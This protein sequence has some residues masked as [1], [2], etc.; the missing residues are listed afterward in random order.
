M[1]VEVTHLPSGLTVVTDAMSHLETA[2]LGV[3]A[4]AGARSEGEKEHGLAHLL[5]HMAFK[6]TR[7][8]DAKRIAEEIESA[9]GELNAATSGEQ[10]AYYAR[11][12]KE[13]VGLGFDILADIL[14]QSVFDSDELAREKNVILQEISAVEDTPDD[15]VFD[16]FNQAAFPHQPL[17]RP[18]LGTPE[19]VMSFDRQAIQAY[20]DTHY[21]AGRMVVAAAG[22]VDHDR[23]VEE[24]G[25]LFA[26]LPEGSGPEPA[27]AIYRGGE[28]V[29]ETD[30]EQA[31]VLIGFGGR[32][33]KDDLSPALGIFT[34][35]VGGGMSSRLF[36]EVREKRGL[37]YQV[38]AFQWGYADTG[39][40]GIS[41]GAGAEDLED[42]VPV[43]LDTV[44]AAASAPTE[45]EIARAK[46]QMKAGLLMA[47]ES[48]AMR[49]EQM[50]RHML[51]WGRPL[52]PAELIA[53]IDAVTA[54]DVRKAGEAVLASPPTL[55]AL[56][57]VRTLPRLDKIR[58]HLAA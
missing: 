13:D 47:L 53:K 28:D 55:A 27:S 40:F 48:S 9:G 20:L 45:A 19:T 33:Y 1:S 11:V 51:I 34:N 7:T 31:N 35:L 14:T 10:T 25:R 41:A 22:A 42:L 6:G 8:R 12:L 54:D 39:I 18:I 37:C 17:G 3:F 38:Y 26:H 50:A 5:E 52:P 36:Q 44:A 57:P 56:G 4:G 15:L 2:S 29:M 30:H 23:V 58:S 32:S 49:A 24:A 43:I 21:R 16:M 46:A